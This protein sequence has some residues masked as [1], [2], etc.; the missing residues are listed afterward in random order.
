MAARKKPRKTQSKKISKSKP[1][2]WKTRD[3]DE[4]A[5]R[6]T[7][8]EKESFTIKGTSKNLKYRG[9]SPSNI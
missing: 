3:E 9:I 8:G 5:R 1:L 6:T 7:R 4:V 2:G